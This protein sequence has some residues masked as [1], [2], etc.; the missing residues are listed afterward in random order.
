MLDLTPQPPRLSSRPPSAAGV[1]TDGSETLIAPGAEPENVPPP[2]VMQAK[3]LSAPGRAGHAPPYTPVVHVHVCA[4][5]RDTPLN[6]PHDALGEKHPNSSSVKRRR[7]AILREALLHAG[8]WSVS[9]RTWEQPGIFTS[10]QRAVAPCLPEEG[11]GKAAR[12]GGG[13]GWSRGLRK[14]T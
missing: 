5:G 10:S 2:S 11:K 7:L 6:A 14:A 12:E 8:T 1:C 3:E 13:R 4:R 9:S